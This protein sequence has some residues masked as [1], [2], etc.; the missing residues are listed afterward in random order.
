MLGRDYFWATLA[1]WG[2]AWLIRVLR[3]FYNS[4]T[5]LSAEVSALPDATLLQ[6][7]IDAPARLAWGPGQHVF[8][9]FLDL[10]LHAFSS[11]PF[12]VASLP[13]TNAAGTRTM[14][15]VI[16]VHGGFTAALARS[17]AG[18]ASVRLPVW[19]DGPYGGVP[20]GLN[21]YD[22]VLL[23]AGGSGA[24]GLL[25]CGSG[26]DVA[27]GAS[28]VAPLLADFA[29][30]SG[31]TAQRVQ[32]V[33]A[34]RTKGLLHSPG[35]HR[36]LT[37]GAAEYGWLEDGVRAAQQA[38]GARLTAHVHITGVHDEHAAHA[39][40]TNS[41]DDEKQ[42]ATGTVFAEGRPDLR[43]LVR[44]ECAGAVGRVAIVG[45]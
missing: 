17:I 29:A 18:R 16:R 28:L 20:A 12:T 21:A 39:S 41:E 5:S 3:T 8:L 36:R 24:R 27:P 44:D 45:A 32:V 22:T 43:A 42:S 37:C 4:S 15:I 13:P 40:A 30:Q 35:R 23:L 2:S 7:S 33:F 31:R 1:V 34:L 25:S 11:H 26:T 38:H 9:R 6:V 10:G 14:H 19:V